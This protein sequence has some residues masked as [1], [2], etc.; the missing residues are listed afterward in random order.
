EDARDARLDKRVP[1]S[2]PPRQELALLESAADD[3][4]DRQLIGS[5]QD[6]DGKDLQSPRRPPDSCV[7]RTKHANGE[8]EHWKDDHQGTRQ[9]GEDEHARALALEDLARQ[10]VLE[11][12]IA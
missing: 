5:Q 1:E 8:D 10:P 7:V 9:P 12:W 11:A 2:Q 4:T 3:L 6:E